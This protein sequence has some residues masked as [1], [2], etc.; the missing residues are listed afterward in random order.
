MIKGRL[1]AFEGINESGKTTQVN[2]LR[3]KLKKL[4]YEIVITKACPTKM[5]KLVDSFVGGFEIEM[6]SMA[7]LF[8]FQALHSKQYEETIQSLKTGKLVIA[9]RWNASFWVYHHN[10]GPLKDEAEKLKILDL[11]AFNGLEPDLVFL[12][13][14]P[15]KLVLSRNREGSIY[16]K[17]NRENVL[18]FYRT[19]R[20]SYLELAKNNNNWIVIDGTL[21]IE[22][23]HKI[24]YRYVKT[25]FK[26]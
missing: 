3:K 19:L 22:E 18:N 25:V 5:K 24:V 17:R 12:M 14:I 11:I 4:G 16:K 13:D 20:K 9:E 7:G 26:R 21:D 10:F 2:L 8:L 6:D 15:A 23:I 1:V